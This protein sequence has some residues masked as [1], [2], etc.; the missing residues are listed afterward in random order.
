MINEKWQTLIQRF[1]NIKLHQYIV[2]SNHFHSILEI[3]NPI[4]AP[5]VNTPRLGDIIGAYKSITAVKYI[6]NVKK[7]IRKNFQKNYGNEIIGT[8]HQK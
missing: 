1:S 6:E 2:M 8:Y 3:T 5:L 7:I 4:R